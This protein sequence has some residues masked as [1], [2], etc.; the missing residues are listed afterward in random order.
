MINQNSHI[1]LEAYRLQDVVENGRPCN[2]LV[3]DPSRIPYA[4]YH[5]LLRQVSVVFRWRC[6]TFRMPVSNLSF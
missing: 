2:F 3:L 6:C 1:A 4:A 5:D